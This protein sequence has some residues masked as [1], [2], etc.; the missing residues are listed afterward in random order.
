METNDLQ[1]LVAQIAAQRPMQGKYLRGLSEQLIDDEAADCERLLQFYLLQ[2]E[3]VASLAEA[4]LMFCDD[5]MEETKYFIEH[6]DYRYHKFSEVAANVYFDESYM[7]KYMIG[8]GLS[9]YLWPQH[10]ACLR[11]FS[12]AYEKYAPAG[13]TYLEIGPGHG[14]Y[15]CDAVR[16][17]RCSAY[18]AADLSETSLRMTQ[19][20]LQHFL[21][22]EEFCQCQFQCTDVTKQAPGAGYDF[23]TMC[24]V[25]EHVEEPLRLLGSLRSMSIR[26]G[27]VFLSVPVN[28]PVKDHIYLFRTVEDV[29]AMVEAAGFEILEKRCFPTR[30][31]TLEKAVKYKDAILVAMFLTGK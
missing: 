29:A 11:F 28:A 15:F 31:R 19:Q 9:L 25:L 3:T 23:I 4:Y 18:T 14:K 6:D 26:G 12:E 17:G 8:L 10:R 16:M 1:T 2:G 5:T 21:T 13:G 20:L 7:W 27:H 30:K 24:E 22:E